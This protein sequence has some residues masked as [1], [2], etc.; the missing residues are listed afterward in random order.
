MTRRKRRRAADQNFY[1]SGFTDEEL[2][3]LASIAR[4]EDLD[5]EIALL[6][7][8]IRR[9]LQAAEART[10][11]ETAPSSSPLSPLGACEPNAQDGTDGCD[12]PRVN[13]AV[14]TNGEA[15]RRYVDTLCRAIRVKSSLQNRTPAQVDEILRAAIDEISGMLRKTIEPGKPATDPSTLANEK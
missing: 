1:A 7:V 9:K 2:A 10:G 8:L 14:Q 3:D 12:V 13:A 5:N 6:K 4:L 11:T 15:I